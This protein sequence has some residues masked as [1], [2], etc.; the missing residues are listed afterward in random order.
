MDVVGPQIGF[1]DSEL[2]GEVEVEGMPAVGVKITR[3]DGSEET[4]YLDPKTYLEMARDCPGSDFGRP[5]DQRTWFD[6]FREVDGVKL[7]FF[8]ET[9][10]YT[11]HRVMQIE[12]VETNVEIDDALFAMP[13]AGEGG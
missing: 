2:L 12:S 8:T 1:L 3:D 5:M 13:A 9:Q 6:D 10:F 7:P 11:R 4:W